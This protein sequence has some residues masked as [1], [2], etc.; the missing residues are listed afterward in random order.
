MTDQTLEFFYRLVQIP[1]KSGHEQAVAE[2]LMQFAQ[3]HGLEAE[4][5]EQNNVIIRKPASA[6]CEDA[7]TVII[8]GHT[9]MVCESAPGVDK[10]FLTEGIDVYEE[11]GW[12]KAR[13]TSM[14]GDD[15]LAVAMA[16]SILEDNSLTLPALECV[17]TTNEETGMDGANALDYSKLKGTMMLNLDTEEE[18]VFCIS[19]AGGGTTL[20]SLEIGRTK[21]NKKSTFRMVLGGMKGGHSGVEIHKNRIN[22]IS[23]AGRVL[24]ALAQEVKLELI[25]FQGGKAHNSVPNRVEIVLNIMPEQRDEL[26]RVAQNTVDEICAEFPTDQCVLEWEELP[27]QWDVWDVDSTQRLINFLMVMPT[28]VLRMSSLLE[29]FVD[30]SQNIGT[31]KQQNDNITFEI[32]VRCGQRHAVVHQMEKNAI[33]THLAGGIAQNTGLYPGWAYREHSPLREMACTLFEEMYGHA[34]KVEGIHAGLECGYFYEA[35]QQQEID[36]ISYGPNILDIHSF[37]ERAEIASIHRVYEFT[38]RLLERIARG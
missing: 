19:S 6:G 34:A 7:P 17:F 30:L 28:G 24:Y 16:L 10:D 1:R 22:G 11:D 29:N 15:G 4:K 35:L 38:V 12:I 13:G 26:M 27:H 18:G 8:Q 21:S 37:H 9:D 36:I 5:D 3:K 33:L 32:S 2:Y 14:G 23:A 31:A 20:A 25:S